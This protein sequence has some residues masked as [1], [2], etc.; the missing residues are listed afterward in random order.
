MPLDLKRYLPE[1]EEIYAEPENKFLSWLK[2]NKE[3]L[4]G[5]LIVFV[6]II[7]FI[8]LYQLKIYCNY[9][10]AIKAYEQ[11]NYALAYEY[12]QE[13]NKS[14][15]EY[16][17]VKKYNDKITCYYNAQ[18]GNNEYNNGNYRQAIE[19][20]NMAKNTQEAKNKKNI[21]V[22]LVERCNLATFLN[23]R[24]IGLNEYNNGNFKEA[25]KNYNLAK[26]ALNLTNYTMN[27]AELIKD[28]NSRISEA[29]K[30]HRKRIAYIN[31]LKTHIISQYDEVENLTYYFDSSNISFAGLSHPAFF[32][33]I[34]LFMT[35]E[36]ANKRL[37]LR[38]SYFG[39]SW[40][41]YSSIIFNIDGEKYEIRTTEIGVPHREV[42]E[43]GVWESSVLLY[44]R[45]KDLIN[46]IINSNKTIMRLSGDKSADYVITE[47]QKQ[48]MQ[49][50]LDYYKF[51]E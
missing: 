21:F 9:T 34:F 12:I 4:I 17:E 13:V 15:P 26:N 38:I 11:K 1:N 16:K 44:D 27:K 28:L 18:L 47:E 2:K 7:T 23:Y 19:Y 41:F 32:S 3:S 25:I 51:V 49:R 48:A 39:D 22:G 6:L 40:I 35:K 36:G 29:Q 46:K 10:N 33:P 5:P 24:N 14:S 43:I 31:Q 30:A 42:A 45:Y 8:M 50:M 37:I 20:Y